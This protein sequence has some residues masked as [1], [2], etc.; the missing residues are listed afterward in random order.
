MND[1]MSFGAVVTGALFVALGVLF[2]LDAFD[3]ARVRADVVLSLAVIALGLA[4]IAGAIW[5]RPEPP[6]RS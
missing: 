6:P 2:M 1:R 3:I 5:R 4:M